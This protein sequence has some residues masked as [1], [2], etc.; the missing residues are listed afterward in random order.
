MGQTWSCCCP[1]TGFSTPKSERAMEGHGRAWRCR[2]QAA[3][4]LAKLSH[5]AEPQLGVGWGGSV[6][7]EGEHLK[8][9]I[10]EDFM[11]R[12]SDTRGNTNL[13][14]MGISRG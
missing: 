2:G 8:E 9:V 12:L 5:L 3:R 6:R 1:H 7:G 4:S 11:V 10:G 14:S 13:H